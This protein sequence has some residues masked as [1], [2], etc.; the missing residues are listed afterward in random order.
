MS[1]FDG[2]IIALLVF[3][4]MYVGTFAFTWYHFVNTTLCFLFVALMFIGLGYDIVR[5]GKVN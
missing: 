2:S 5:S 4:D 3:V 1:E